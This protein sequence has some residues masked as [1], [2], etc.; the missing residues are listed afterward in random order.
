MELNVEALE[1]IFPKTEA[2]NFDATFSSFSQ[3]EAS[4]EIKTSG[5]LYFVTSASVK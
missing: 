1:S 5:K 2:T 4:K 3:S